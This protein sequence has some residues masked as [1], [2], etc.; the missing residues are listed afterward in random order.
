VK[1]WIVVLAFVV[2]LLFHAGLLTFGG[3]LFSRPG[4]GRRVR[5]DV[6]LVADFAPEDEKKSES[7]DA[8]KK[9]EA[10]LDA[11]EEARDTL[12]EEIEAIPDLKD[13]AALES[14]VAA[15][16]LAA[17]SLSALESALGAG[18]SGGGEFGS[19]FSLSSGGR[20]GGVGV[21]GDGDG[22][23][24]DILSVAELDQRPRPILQAAPQ[25]PLEL[26]KNKVEGTV[27]V[28][29]YVDKDGRVLNPQVERSSHPAFERPALEAVRQW[30]FEAGTRSGHRV[31]FKMRVPISFHVS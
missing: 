20:I 24:D 29:F 22:G 26:R 9:A 21:A 10:A 7:K 15:P 11:T 13:L 17:M 5:E 23:L 2:A 18:P 25:Y 12:R 16:A 27:Q 4:D 31:N 28:V 14:P 1:R 30:R 19:G 8:E 6:E 3:L